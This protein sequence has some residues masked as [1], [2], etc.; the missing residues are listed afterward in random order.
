VIV[1]NSR[2]CTSRSTCNSYACGAPQG[3]LQ[4]SGFTAGVGAQNLCALRLNGCYE[5]L[6]DESTN[7]FPHFQNEHGHTFY[8]AVTPG[9][10][11][12]DA[13]ADTIPLN[14]WGFDQCYDYQPASQGAKCRGPRAAWIL[15]TPEGRPENPHLTTDGPEHLAGAGVEGAVLYPFV[16]DSDGDGGTEDADLALTLLRGA[17]ATAAVQQARKA[18]DAVVNMVHAQ[19]TGM[20]VLVS[21]CPDQLCNG[22][23][24][25]QGL[26][27]TANVK[28]PHFAN[29][30]SHYLF[31]NERGCDWRINETLPDDDDSW[32]TKYFIDSEHLLPTGAQ[33]WVRES[34]NIDQM[35]KD[36][37]VSNADVL[38]AQTKHTLVVKLRRRRS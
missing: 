36:E 3:A 33:A 18:A 21:G 2:S 37:S 6:P 5:R 11:P 4:V 7:G 16:A 24:T 9:D 34:E 29:E 10:M 15:A 26:R 14:M 25:W 1:V 17:T 13:S 35:V 38:A 19:L 8:Y 12:G 32:A 31:R 23:Y 30:H 28:Y 20:D 22:R 27:A